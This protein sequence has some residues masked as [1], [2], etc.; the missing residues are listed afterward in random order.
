MQG[1]RSPL[2]FVTDLDFEAQ[3]VAKLALKRL[4]VGVDHFRSVAA[5]PTLKVGARPSARLLAPRTFLGL[6]NRIA[7]GN[8]LESEFFGIIGAGDRPRVAHADIAFQ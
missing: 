1:H 8:D 5:T 4:E 6:A 3:D 7:P 2:P